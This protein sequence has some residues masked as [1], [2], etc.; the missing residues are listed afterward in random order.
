MN[1]QLVNSDSVCFETIPTMCETL[2]AVCVDEVEANGH[3][4]EC[5][6][7]L[8]ATMNTSGN[9]MEVIQNLHEQMLDRVGGQFNL[10]LLGEDIDEG[11]TLE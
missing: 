2:N 4:P 6:A 11:D 3:N 5:S 8:L 7:M 1:L 9:L 10:T